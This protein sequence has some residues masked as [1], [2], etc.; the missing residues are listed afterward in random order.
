MSKARCLY[1]WTDHDC[2]NHDCNLDEDHDGRH[3]CYC[4]AHSEQTVH[5][6][7]R[8]TTMRFIN[9]AHEGEPLFVIRGRDALAIPVLRAYLEECKRH[10][11]WGQELRADEHLTRFRDWQAQNAKLT[12]LPDPLPTAEADHA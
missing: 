11:L 12:H 3:A 10:E 5:E 9:S 7:D 8:E 6:G 2:N 1:H 4:G